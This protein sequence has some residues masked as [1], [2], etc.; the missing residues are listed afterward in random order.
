LLAR[1]DEGISQDHPAYLKGN[2][3]TLRRYMLEYVVTGGQGANAP[4]PGA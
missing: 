1:P 4:K 3:E 2:R